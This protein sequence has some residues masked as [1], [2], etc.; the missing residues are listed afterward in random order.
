LEGLSQAAP[1]ACRDSEG[2]QRDLSVA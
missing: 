1:C 2:L